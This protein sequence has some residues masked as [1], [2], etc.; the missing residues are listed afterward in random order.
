MFTSCRQQV[1]EIMGQSYMSITVSPC[2]SHS[3]ELTTDINISATLPYATGLAILHYTY[4]PDFEWHQECE[5]HSI[6]ENAF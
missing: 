3:D 5:L 1:G 2:Q 4:H 6:I